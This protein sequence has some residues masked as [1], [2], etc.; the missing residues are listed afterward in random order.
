MDK[1]IDDL[2]HLARKWIPQSVGIEVSG[3]QGGFISWIEKEMMNRNFFFTLASENNTG[4]PGIRP[5]K[6]KLTRFNTVV[7]WFKQGKIHLPESRRHEGPL[8]EMVDEITTVS[9]AGFKSAHD[10][11]ADTISMLSVLDVWLPVDLQA[12]AYEDKY[13]SDDIDEEEDALSSYIV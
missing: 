1:N 7:P 13:W 8:T 9:P 12:T 6:D 3:Q 11:S 10:D 4:K 5:N 2:F